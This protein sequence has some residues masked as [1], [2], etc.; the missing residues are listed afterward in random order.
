MEASVGIKF[1]SSRGS[2]FNKCRKIASLCFSFYSLLSYRFN[3]Q[4]NQLRKYKAIYEG[5]PY[6]YPKDD[7]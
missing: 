1:L 6:Q 4:V 2:V 5:K 3:I 7:C